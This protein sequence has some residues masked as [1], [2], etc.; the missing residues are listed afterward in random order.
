M[1]KGGISPGNT[2]IFPP[3]QNLRL[4]EQFFRDSKQCVFLNEQAR[5]STFHR[6]KATMSTNSWLKTAFSYFFVI[7]LF[8]AHQFSKLQSLATPSDIPG[9]YHGALLDVI[10]HI[11]LLDPRAAYGDNN[12]SLHNEHHKTSFWIPKTN[13]HYI[14]QKSNIYF[15]VRLFQRET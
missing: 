8:Y 11:A 5:I 12:I 10:H 3:N 7:R 1:S 15:K 4:T 6:L 14:L 2:V 9:M 13:T